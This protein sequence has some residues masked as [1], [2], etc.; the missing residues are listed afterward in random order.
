MHVIS[1]A[2]LV[3]ASRDLTSYAPYLSCEVLSPSVTNST[4]I[5]YMSRYMRSQARAARLP[6]VPNE[7]VLNVSLNL[8]IERPSVSVEDNPGPE[9]TNYDDTSHCDAVNGT[10]LSQTMSSLMPENVPAS[11]SL[12]A[13][14]PPLSYDSF[15][16]TIKGLPLEPATSYQSFWNS[17]SRPS[18]FSSTP[19]GDPLTSSSSFNVFNT[20]S[21]SSIVNTSTHSLDSLLFQVPLSTIS[22]SNS[23]LGPEDSPMDPFQS[24]PESPSLKRKDRQDSSASG[25]ALP[26]PVRIFDE[27]DPKRMKTSDALL[28]IPQKM[29]KVFDFLKTLKWTVEDF[30]RHLFEPQNHKTNRSQRHGVAVKRFL[31]GR[32]RYTVAN[33]LNALWTTSDGASNDLS[34]FYCVDTPYIEIK[35]VRAALS[36]FAAQIV[37]VRLIQEARIAVEESSGMHASI[38]SE[39]FDS[40]VE[41]A[42]IGASLIPTVQANLQQ[43]QPLAFHYMRRIAEPKPQ[44]RNGVV[45]VRV[46]RPPQLVTINPYPHFLCTNVLLGRNSGSLR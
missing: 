8:D 36:S 7:S 42:D 23:S 2:S 44:R 24:L 5:L 43:H 37:E 40:G 46:N 18:T 4:V 38:V 41:W 22:I 15:F 21:T 32:D 12:A 17:V 19:S 20:P 11:D 35:P 45:A 30:L 3:V 34:G 26:V 13:P 9:I 16:D 39:D 10:L 33:L 28:P 25:Y 14:L 29:D 1:G 6:P 31:S 27:P